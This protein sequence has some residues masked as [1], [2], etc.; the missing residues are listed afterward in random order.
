MT[1]YYFTLSESAMTHLIS[2]YADE[3]SFRQTLVHFS[4][5]L[6]CDQMLIK[7]FAVKC[8]SRFFAHSAENRLK[9]QP[10]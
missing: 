9:R 3:R 1:A 4:K 6:P 7:R 10:Q 2:F 8:N 5:M